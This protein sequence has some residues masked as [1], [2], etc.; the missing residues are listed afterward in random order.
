MA[1]AV[2]TAL[3]TDQRGFSL[4]EYNGGLENLPRLMERWSN[5]HLTLLGGL[6]ALW[7][8]EYAAGHPTRLQ[9]QRHRWEQ[10]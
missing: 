6:A 2:K 8:S 7:E 3:T 5:I 10:R 1:H 4:L 9:D